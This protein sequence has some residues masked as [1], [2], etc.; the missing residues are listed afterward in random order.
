MLLPYG[1][2]GLILATKP[3]CLAYLFCRLKACG[4][5][6]RLDQGWTPMRFG[7]YG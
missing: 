4:L 6:T 1:F 2:E 5:F 7:P 3:P